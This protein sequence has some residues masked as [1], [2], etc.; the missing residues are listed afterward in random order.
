MHRFGSHEPCSAAETSPARQASPF[1]TL[2]NGWLNVEQSMLYGMDNYV[3]EGMVSFPGGWVETRQFSWST[4]LESVFTT[5]KR[6]YMVNLS[7]SGWLT[8]GTAKNLHARRRHDT[9]TIGR[10]MLVPPEQALQVNSIKGQSRSIRCVLDAEL[11]EAFLGDRPRWRDNDS[12]LHAALNISS[13]QIE[14]LLRR[15]YRELRHPDFATAQVVEA[16]AKQLTVEI[17]RTLKLRRGDSADH[18]GGLAPWHLSLIRQRLRCEDALPNLEELA[19]L[20]D[21]T[22]RHLSRAFRSET[23]QTIGKHIEAAMVDRANRMLRS[24]TPVREVTL[25]LGYAT[26]ASFAAAFRRATGLLPSE[27]SSIGRLRGGT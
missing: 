27:V 15:M 5:T 17:I 16:L 9:E 18:V 24:G 4:P 20:C 22:V 14:W 25:A 12:S 1:R 19:N 3:T 8:G 7:L 26:S 11:F 2:Y 10:M 23:G 21:M 6:C 13:G